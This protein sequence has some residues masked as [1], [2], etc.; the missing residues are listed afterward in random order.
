MTKKRFIKL[1]MAVG[2]ER[3]SAVNS[4]AVTR[5]IGCSYQQFYDEVMKPVLY[6]EN[7]D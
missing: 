4:C 7:G 3:N 1:L 2:V 6:N 5:R